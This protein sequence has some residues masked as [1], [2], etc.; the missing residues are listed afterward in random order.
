M[1]RGIRWIQL[2]IVQNG[3]SPEP[4]SYDDRMQARH[5]NDSHNWTLQF[6]IKYIDIDI[7]IDI[8]RKYFSHRGKA[9]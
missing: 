6:M 3:I 9:V 1:G 2:F 4:L 7:D 8:T 5:P